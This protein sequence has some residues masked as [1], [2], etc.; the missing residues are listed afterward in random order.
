MN[1]NTRKLVITALLVAVGLL[2]PFLTGQIPPIGSALSPLHIPVLL[3]G[4]VCGGFWGALCGFIL[5]LLRSLL[6]TMPPMYPA[7]IAMAFEM[8]TYGLVTGLMYKR[9]PKG[10]A[11]TLISLITA[12]L[13]GRVVWGIA[14]YV[15][16][17]F[18]PSQF[19][20]ALF[21]AGAFADAIPGIIL[22]II[23]IPIIVTAL[24]RANLISKED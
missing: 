22:H 14:R 2:L 18:G 21:I 17:F 5:P 6:F 19:S 1:K 3:C 20:V 23:L 12:M 7:A 15:L 9:T 13:C 16:T 8:A 4:F 10:I 24:E 11:G